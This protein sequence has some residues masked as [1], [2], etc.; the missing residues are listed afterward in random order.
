[1]THSSPVGQGETR[2]TTLMDRT[3]NPEDTRKQ[4]FWQTAKNDKRPKLK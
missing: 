1:M 4:V 2:L 3:R